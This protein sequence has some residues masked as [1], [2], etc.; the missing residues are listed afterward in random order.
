MP[1]SSK[2]KP[3]FTKVFTLR[4]TEEE[5]GLA[6]QHAGRMALGAYIRLIVLKDNVAPRMR[7][8]IAVI[9][10]EKALSKLFSMLGASRIFSN[11][12]QIAKAVNQ[13]VLYL[14]PE[15]ETMLREACLAVIQ[16]RDLLMQSLGKRERSDP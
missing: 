6:K 8:S 2:K 10:D 16:M 14:S 11:L 5:Y 1:E 4:F 15:M 3:R 13:G 7:Q 9:K 12:N